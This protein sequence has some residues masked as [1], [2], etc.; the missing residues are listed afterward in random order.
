LGRTKHFLPAVLLAVASVSSAQ[1]TTAA[2]PAPETTHWGVD[3]LNSGVWFVVSESKFVNV[4]GMIPGTAFSGGADINNRDFTKSKLSFTLRA[5]ALTTN[6]PGLWERLMKT[7][8]GLLKQPGAEGSLEVAQYP[9]ITFVSSKITKN[10]DRIQMTGALTLHGVTKMVTLD[11]APPPPIITDDG[12][13]YH[14]FEGTTVINRQDFGIN[15]REPEHRTPPLF[16]DEIK[17][18]VIVELV[19]PPLRQEQIDAQK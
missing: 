9:T 11:V 4:H 7:G 10:G 12:T 1:Q 16:D 5:A 17:I 18:T 2:A 6:G 15:W 19:N 13:Q 8:Q 3:P 14:P